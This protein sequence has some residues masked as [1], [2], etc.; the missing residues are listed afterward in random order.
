MGET[1]SMGVALVATLDHE[2]KHHFVVVAV[3]DR[4]HKDQHTSPSMENSV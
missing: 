2:P 4:N 1:K 3:D